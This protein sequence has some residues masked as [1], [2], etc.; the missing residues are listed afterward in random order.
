MKGK[1]C[2]AILRFFVLCAVVAGL[3]VA[4]VAVEIRGKHASEGLKCVDCHLVDKPVAEA[5][6]NVCLECH[7]GFEKVAELTKSLHGNP[8]D[9]HLGKMQ[10]LKCHRIHRPSEIICLE[11]HSDFDF[12]EK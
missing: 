3:S 1:I 12:K 10:C 4:A 7:G 5:S 8:H 6:V 9:S 2:M 11:C